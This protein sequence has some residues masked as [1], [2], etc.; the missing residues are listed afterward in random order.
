VA[1]KD[2]PKPFLCGAAVDSLTESPWLN[3][4]L[5]PIAARNFSMKLGRPGYGQVTHPEL[6]QRIQQLL[7]QLDAVPA[8]E[9]FHK[10]NS[11]LHN[12]RKP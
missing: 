7:E 4:R 9:Q 11:I 3:Q 12:G 6:R 10:T 1:R 8:A 2:P 5:V